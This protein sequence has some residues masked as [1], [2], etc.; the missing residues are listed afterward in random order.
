MQPFVAFLTSA[1]LL[2]FFLWNCCDEDGSTT[3]NTTYKKW[4]LL[5]PEVA[6]WERDILKKVE[7]IW[8][9]IQQLLYNAGIY[10]FE[11]LSQVEPTMIKDILL[12]AWDNFRQHDPVTRPLQAKMA[13]EWKWVQLAKRQDELKGW[14]L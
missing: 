14:R 5:F 6:P 12:D 2:G 7:W 9:K 13:H 11:Q 8:P 3:E 1:L 10:T 4:N